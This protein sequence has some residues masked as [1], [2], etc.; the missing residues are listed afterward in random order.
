MRR[1]LLVSCL[2]LTTSILPA[3][4]I[5]V[6]L[7]DSGMGSLRQA[8]LDVPRDGTVTFDASLAGKS[9]GLLSEIEL[10]QALTIDAT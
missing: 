9:I 6:N 8:I 3:Q 10:D 4:E 1:F 2:F 5:V 7:E